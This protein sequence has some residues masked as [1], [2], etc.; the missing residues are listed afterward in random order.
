MKFVVFTTGLALGVL[1]TFVVQYHKPESEKSL[2]TETVFVN[3]F[4]CVKQVI[5]KGEYVDLKLKLSDY[6]EE[7]KGE[8][9]LVGAGVYFRDL[10][11][12]PTMGIN[13]YEEYSTASLL[14]VPTLIAYLSLS[15]DNPSLLSEEIALRDGFNGGSTD[16]SQFYAPPDE[17]K[18]DTA[19]TVEALLTRLTRYSDNAA[20]EMLR[21]Y[22]SVLS[23]NDIIGETYKE[24]G[25]VPEESGGDYVI[26]VKRY[27]SIFR[28]LYNASYL[29]I[30]KSEKALRMLSESTFDQGIVAGVP[31]GTLVAHKFGE[32][33][34]IETDPNVK[35]LR[36]LHDCGIVYFPENPYTLCVMTLGYDFETLE[37]VIRDISRM[38]YEEVESRKIPDTQ[39][40]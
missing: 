40:K 23:P 31:K 16:F 28:I 6:I 39:N 15:E 30:E 26:T 10:R 18:K 29:S 4:A 17:L 21:A 11:N 5:S 24:L 19:Y 25:L 27:A 32:R 36:Q 34:F 1:L 37:T 3:S 9:S 33:S 14:K 13:E 22:L 12:G 7:K 20:S 38:T 2:C 8:G 35:P